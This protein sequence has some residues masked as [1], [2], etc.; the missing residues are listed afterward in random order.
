[1]TV[2]TI[3]EKRYGT[4]FVAEHI[5]SSPVFISLWGIAGLSSMMYIIKKKLY[6]KLY[7]FTIHIAFAVILAGA[8]V[9]HIKGEQG[10][11][12]LRKDSKCCYK[13][14]TFDNRTIELP[15]RIKLEDF[16]IKNYPG[17]QSPMDYVSKVTIADNNTITEGCVSMND[18]LKYRNYR[19]YQ[20]GFD[21]DKNGTT[22]SVYHDPYGIAITYSG[23]FLLLVGM[24]MFFLEK[25][26]IFR[27]LIK[28]EYIR[29][30]N[31]MLVMIL[32]SLFSLSAKADVPQ[33]VPSRIAEALGSLN[34]YY[35]GRICPLQTLALDFTKKVHGKTNYKGFTAEEVLAGCFFYYDD[36]K[37][38]PFIRI[39]SK[40]VQ[41]VLGTGEYACISDFVDINGFKLEKALQRTKNAVQRR[42]LEEANEKFNI[43]SM[44]CTGSLLKIFPV[45]DS[46]ANSCKWYSVSEKPSLE[47]P[48]EKWMFLKYSMNYVSEHIYKKDF[49]E[50][51]KIIGK[52]KEYQKKEAGEGIPG[53]FRIE[54]ERFYNSWNRI[55][56]AAILCLS[57]GIGGFFYQIILVRKRRSTNTV[58]NKILTSGLYIIMAYTLSII[59]MRGV[60]SARFPIA[61]GYE[62]M[63]FMATTCFILTVVFKKHI[64][65]FT[66]FGYLTGGMALLVAMLGESNPAITPLMPV[67]S[68]P[69]LSI[70]VMTIMIS[71]SLF[72]IMM[73]NGI[74]AE[75]MLYCKND[76]KAEI[77]RLE[78]ISRILL[79]PAVF[80]LASGIFIGAIWANVSWGRYWGWD[81]K[82]V[83]ALITMLIYSSALHSESLKIFSNTKFFHGFTIIAFLSVVITYFGV[84]FILGGMHSY[85]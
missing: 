51:E 47:M 68:S 28:S 16:S 80:L 77:K 25:H 32:S 85:A 61:N 11:I 4:E 59:I 46:V 58:T 57:I 23:Y 22:L 76:M 74:T 39:K 67:L 70:H 30:V 44:L 60:I 8:L 54:T 56:L 3:L 24:I 35:N 79:Y 50:A 15:F 5:Y 31:L 73:L 1:M 65:G 82:E 41:S 66:S 19:F 55:K 33:T 34:L 37:E 69:L 27:K 49:K 48:H 71:Y 83:W 29:R 13:F 12:H 62:T 84:N 45:R 14:T 81:P 36:W 26:S 21:E 53:K 17:T 9:T 6:K 63:L 7:I 18:I 42:E 75:T 10:Y 43:T 40:Y 20:S 64:L 78:T 72:A 2:A 38:E 52:I